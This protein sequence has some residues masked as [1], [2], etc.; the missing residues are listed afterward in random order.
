MR[1]FIFSVW[2][3]SSKTAIATTAA[4][5][6]LAAKQFSVAEQG[7]RHV[8]SASVQGKSF[9]Y[10]MPAG[11]G[12]SDFLN[13]AHDS[14]RLLKIGGDTGGA[15]TDAELESYLTDAGGQQTNRTVASFTQFTR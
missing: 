11:Q 10:E 13:M 12:G 14:W 5:E 15:M 6:T 1:A 3:H 7:G 4:M 9:S 2:V 8:V